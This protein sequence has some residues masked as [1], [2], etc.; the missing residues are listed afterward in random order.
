MKVLVVATNRYRNPMPVMPM[1][2]CIAAESVQTAGRTVRLLDLMFERS[3]ERALERELLSFPPDVVGFSVRNIDNNESLAPQSLCDELIPLAQCTRRYSKAFVVMGGAALGVMPE[4]LL[5]AARADCAVLGDGEAVFPAL[6]A[7]LQ[8]GRGLTG[9]PG[10]AWLEGDQMRVNPGHTRHSLDHFVGP[11]YARWLD[12]KKYQ[13][14]LCIAGVQT[15][16]G[17]PYECVY[18]TYP[19]AEG[20]A[21]RLCPPETV[22]EGIGRLVQSGVRDI[23]FVDSVFNSPYDHA[24][25]VCE[26]LAETGTGARLHAT[27]LNPALVDGPLLDAMERAGFV[28]MGISAES[29]SDAALAGLGKG[30]ASAE[31]R[32]AAEAVRTSP[33]PCLWMFLLGGPGESRETVHET[34]A[35]AHNHIRPSDTAFFSIGIRVYPST[36]LDP[37]ARR[38]GTLRVVP[39]HMLEP[40]FY[41][42][43]GL[44]PEWLLE[45]VDRFTAIHPNMV[46]PRAAGLSFLPLVYRAGYALGM[47][48]PLWKHTAAL[49]RLAKLVGIRT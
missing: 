5:R 18:C 48:P 3:P 38:E 46:G 42:P 20:T 29:A 22:A 4:A 37:V 14:C 40:C 26:A 23:E 15:K 8:E 16:R 13:R 43:P 1:G 28:A 39:D 36:P 31:V 19:L 30:Y 33:L 6:L 32:R 11:D 21:H 45:E 2:A 44:E 34:L 17:C 41:S 27:S 10:V 12:L 24:L 35:F 7:A 9:V 47:R 25:A 49:R